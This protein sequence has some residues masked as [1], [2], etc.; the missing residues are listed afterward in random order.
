MFVSVRFGPEHSLE[1]ISRPPIITVYS[2]C[3]QSSLKSHGE[4]NLES[5]SYQRIMGVARKKSGFL[6]SEL[7]VLH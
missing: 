6:T 7:G 2:N 3:L 1:C 5:A 4:L